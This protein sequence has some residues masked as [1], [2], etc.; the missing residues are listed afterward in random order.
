ME[1]HPGLSLDS[2]EASIETSFET[3]DRVDTKLAGLIEEQCVVVGTGRAQEP[4]YFKSLML[5]TA[6]LF[7]AYQQACLKNEIVV[8]PVPGRS[9]LLQGC[10]HLDCGITNTCLNMMQR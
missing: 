8:P 7:P 6:G 1:T 10:F 4:Q 9:K 2:L 3:Q 5:K